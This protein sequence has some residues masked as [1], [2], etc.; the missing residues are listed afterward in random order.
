M[1][2]KHRGRLLQS[3]IIQDEIEKTPCSNVLHKWLVFIRLTGKAHHTV[4]CILSKDT[5]IYEFVEEFKE[6]TGASIEKIFV[7]PLFLNTV[8][9]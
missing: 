5:N 6:R 2:I 9:N 3:N 1:C 8:L 7:H 4:D